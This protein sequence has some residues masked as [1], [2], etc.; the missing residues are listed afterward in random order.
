[1]GQ[2]HKDDV[3]KSRMEL[4]LFDALVE[5][6][7]VLTHGSKKYAPNNWRKVTTRRNGIPE[8]FYSIWWH[9]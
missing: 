9:G 4:L 6:A 3:G 7:K 8:R 5:V 2:G 1:M